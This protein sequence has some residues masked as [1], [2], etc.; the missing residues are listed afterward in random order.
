MNKN[1]VSTSFRVH[2]APES[3]SKYTTIEVTRISICSAQTSKMIFAGFW[4]CFDR[5]FMNYDVPMEEVWS[6]GT[7]DSPGMVTNK[8][9]LVEF[10]SLRTE[11]R[12][13]SPTSLAHV[14]NLKKQDWL[15]TVLRFILKKNN[16]IR[17]IINKCQ[18]LV[19]LIYGNLWH[20]DNKLF[21]Y[22]FVICIQV[23]KI[24]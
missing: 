3:W 22:V 13:T 14:V 21:H 24:L 11:E 19:K 23:L 8:R 18:V 16:A 12:S 10:R 1:S 15:R 9:S 20:H 2:A 6:F 17:M 5:C 4:N 7:F